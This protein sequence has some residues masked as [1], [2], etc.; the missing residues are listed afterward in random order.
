MVGLVLDLGLVCI[1][2]LAIVE[3]IS[4]SVFSTVIT[5]SDLILLVSYKVL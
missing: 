1:A 2:V 5:I 4:A 3:R